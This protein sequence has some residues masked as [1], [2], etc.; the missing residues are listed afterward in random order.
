MEQN[1]KDFWVSVELVSLTRTSIPCEIFLNVGKWRDKGITFRFCNN[2]IQIKLELQ[3]IN[4]LED[5]ELNNQI[6]LNLLKHHYKNAVAWYLLFKVSCIRLSLYWPAVIQ[7]RTFQYEGFTQ[8]ADHVMHQIFPNRIKV[9]K[10]IIWADQESCIIN[11][12]YKC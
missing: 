12:V 9:G 11:N 4:G 7:K 8:N 5:I 6:G 1:Q 10:I 2:R 3:L